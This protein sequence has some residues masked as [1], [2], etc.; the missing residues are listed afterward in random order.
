MLEEISVLSGLEVYTPWGVKIGDVA[1]VEIESETSSIENLFLETTN[2]KLV[3]EG[4]SILI[5]FRWVQAVGDIII[6]KHFPDD[7]PISSMDGPELEEYR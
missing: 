3:S 7:L 2:E 6:L 4:D 5:P 1:N